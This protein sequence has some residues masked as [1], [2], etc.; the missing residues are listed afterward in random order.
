[1][2]KFVFKNIFSR[3]ERATLESSSTFLIISRCTDFSM[4][5]LFNNF[6]FSTPYARIP[7]RS[8]S[9]LML[10]F[11][12]FPSNPCWFSTRNL[13][14]RPFFSN[15]RESL[16]GTSS[17]FLNLDRIGS[18][19]FKNEFEFNDL[20]AALKPKL[21]IRQPICRK[22]FKIYKKKKGER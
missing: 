4:W 3:T 12:T 13:L 18:D 9:E 21:V 20:S 6:S 1:M 14:I 2:I 22:R 7:G 17:K 8:S 15:I 19:C 11:S 16:A 5:P 10:I